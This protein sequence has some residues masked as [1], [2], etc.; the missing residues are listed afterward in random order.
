M[1]KETIETG[2]YRLPQQLLEELDFYRLE[3]ERFQRGEISD[4]AFKAFRVPWGIYSQRGGQTY[5]M[6]IKLPAGGLT[7]IQME[8]L[9]Y[10]S[11]RYGDGIPHVTSRQGVQ[12]HRVRIEDTPAVLEALSQVSLT[13]RGGGGN[14]IRNI[15]TCAEAGICSEEAFDVTPHAV[16]LSERLMMDPRSGVLPRKFKVAFSGCGRDCALST[17]NDLGFIA[18]TRKVGGREERG[19]AVYAAGGMGAHSR[20]ADRLEDFIPEAEVFNVTEAVLRIFDRMGDRHNRNRARLRFVAEKLGAAE[21][22]KV[23]REELRRVR[24]APHEPLA[25]RGPVGQSDHPPDP[26]KDKG[27]GQPAIPTERQ[28]AI[29]PQRQAGYYCVE[30]HLPLG[31]IPAQQLRA[32]AEVVRRLGEGTVRTAHR[33]NILLRGLRQEELSPLCQ[34]LQGIGLTLMGAR[35][36]SD[37]L[38]C[39]GAN[40]CN[41]GICLSRNLAAEIAQMLRDDGLALEELRGVDIQVSGCP[42]ACGH[43]PIAAVGLHGLARRANGRPAPHY[44]VLL[45]GRVE[46][47]ETTL[48]RE[49]GVVPARCVPELIHT[50]LNHYLS[51]RQGGESFHAFLDRRGQRDMEALIHDR[52]EIPAH[53]E[54]PEFYVD[55][56]ASEPFSLAGLG[57]GECGAG[58]RDLIESDIEEAGRYLYRAQRR[59]QEGD[60]GDPAADLNRALSLA[61]RALLVTRGV[62]PETD[63][64]AFAQFREQFVETGWVSNRYLEIADAA[65]KVSSGDRVNKEV[66]DYVGILIDRVRT[67]YNSMDASLQLHAPGETVAVEEEEPVTDVVDEEMDLRGVE[68]PFNYVQ[69]KLR[70]E[71]MAVGQVLRLLLDEGE[72]IQNVPVSLENDEQDVQSLDPVDGH[73]E[74]VVQKCV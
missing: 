51:K 20:V 36:V 10:L 67:L 18:K 44:R 15:T 64:E 24:E 17:V 54:A 22:R 16:V 41:L 6:R 25:L 52:E 47:G 27:N 43:H 65:G 60:P 28:T 49:A 48:G 7:P 62:Q 14:T 66:L 8:T 19:F 69:A 21:F 40:T 9:A 55:W 26:E 31:L 39:P 45:G 72:P 68:C 5:M 63:G 35:G 61:T 73:Y 11:E 46:E 12:L 50:F 38:S 42:N 30:A 53:D 32:L 70:L 34:A 4:E 58:V 57:P 13:T 37:V 33:Q 56:G 1:N 71:T 23:Y 59:H 2:F 74:V 3:V 29:H